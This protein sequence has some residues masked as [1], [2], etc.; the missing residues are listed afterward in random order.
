MKNQKS[1]SLF[2]THCHLSSDDYDDFQ[3]SSIID[4]A[5][6]NQVKHII[7]VGYDMLTNERLIKQYIDDESF[8]FSAIGIHPN[9]NDDLTDENL[10]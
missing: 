10:K 1:I 4:E 8:L 2:D 7:N 3:V 5:K 9:S 6:R